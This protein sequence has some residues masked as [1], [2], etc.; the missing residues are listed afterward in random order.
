MQIMSKDERE[1]QGAESYR[2]RP[3]L[4]V[5]VPP[6]LPPFCL[7]LVVCAR[8]LLVVGEPP[9]SPSA[10]SS[11]LSS[12]APSDPSSSPSSLAPVSSDPTSS[13]PAPDPLR[14]SISTWSLIERVPRV[15]W[16]ALRV[17]FLPRDG[18]GDERGSITGTRIRI[19]RLVIIIISHHLYPLLYCLFWTLLAHWD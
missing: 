4:L 12:C 6:P 3:P 13:S 17:P 1:P 5:P 8:V 9:V 19:M 16:R 10:W 2:R 7:D 11:S 14:D 15:P 18:A